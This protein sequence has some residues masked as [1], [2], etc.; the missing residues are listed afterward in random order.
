M[1]SEGSRIHDGQLTNL[2]EKHGVTGTLQ[3]NRIK[4]WLLLGLASAH[5]L[6]SIFFV[7]PGYLLIDE[8]L[9]HWTV[10]NLSQSHD[11]TIWNGFE[12][13]PSLELVHHHF[14]I[15]SGHLFPTWPPLIAVFQLPFYLLFG[16]YGLF[17]LNS[18]AF[19]GTVILVFAIAKK[20]LDDQDLA[21]NSC[22]IFALCTFGW[23]YSQAAWPHA[24]AMFFGLSSFYL[25][26]YAYYAPKSSGALLYSF[27]A[28]LMA[29]LATGL[30]Y[31]SIFYLGSV[32]LLFFFARPWRLREIFMICLGAAPA[33][34]LSSTVHYINFGVFWPLYR[35]TSF[36]GV[37]QHESPLGFGLVAA[38]FIL[39]FWVATRE[40]YSSFVTTNRKLFLAGF[41]GITLLAITIPYTRDII[42]LEANRVYKMVVDLRIH[43]PA[44]MEPASSRSAS[45]GLVY[46]NAQKKALLQSLPYLAVLFIPFFRVLRADSE[47]ANLCILFLVPTAFVAFISHWNDHGGLCLNM[48]YLLPVLPFTSILTAYAWRDLTLRANARFHFGLLAVIAL[49]TG[50][51]YFLFVDRVF[52]T[53][54]EQEFPMLIMPLLLAGA[55]ALLLLLGEFIKS[56][57]QKLLRHVSVILVV[58]SLMWAALI[59]F[60][61]DYSVHR[62]QRAIN[63]KFGEELL[64]IVPPDSIF[65]TGPYIDCVLRL[66]E[67]NKVRIAFPFQDKF[68]DF[69]Q[70]VDFHLKV[71]RQVLAMFPPELWKNL[72]KGPLAPYRV[73]PL[74]SSRFFL[75]GEIV[76]KSAKP[77]TSDR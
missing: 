59:A 24:T 64:R 28:G 5:I 60:S 1:R 45:G 33:L 22:L 42:F 61:Y 44:I 74:V 7:I 62:K 58:I 65:F 21:L 3:R 4:L 39:I 54:D 72:E 51:T 40:R 31:D 27:A 29:G 49:L 37:Y 2:L 53:I 17:V 41:V 18:I 69:P 68:R 30:R 57:P 76:E 32:V 55:L 63:F 9:Y 50:V 13:F 71:G 48:R 38:C 46:M 77:N 23:E 25:G 20:I 36:L 34:T 73:I 11:Y 16:F 15:H 52:L 14:E 67:G 66:I 19:M 70:L 47:W 6:I 75:I 10:K 12:E 8:A 56:E 43:D 26:V 35:G